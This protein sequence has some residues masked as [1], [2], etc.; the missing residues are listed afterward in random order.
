MGRRDHNKQLFSENKPMSGR[1]DFRR[2]LQAR[3]RMKI[4]K[5]HQICKKYIT[6]SGSTTDAIFKLKVNVDQIQEFKPTKEGG[7]WQNHQK[8]KLLVKIKVTLKFD[9]VTLVT[10][11]DRCRSDR[12]TPANLTACSQPVLPPFCCR[13][14]CRLD[15]SSYVGLSV[16]IQ[17]NTP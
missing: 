13:L 6:Q 3:R 4:D 1:F 12:C 9:E 14:D 5:K 7:E 11:P 17:K 16:E 15:R 2:S 10:P 8:P